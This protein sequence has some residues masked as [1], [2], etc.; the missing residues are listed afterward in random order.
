MASFEEASKVPLLFNLLLQ[1]TVP[2]SPA[3]A[4]QPLLLE[5][6]AKL[7]RVLHSLP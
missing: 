5:S 7:C 6:T 2:V 1:Q 4:V 3:L